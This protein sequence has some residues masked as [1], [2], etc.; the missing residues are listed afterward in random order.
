MN[1]PDTSVVFIDGVKFVLQSD[2]R[3]WVV[4]R[5]LLEVLDDEVS[6]FAHLPLELLEVDSP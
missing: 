2:G 6:L 4:E 1:T 5:P 3:L